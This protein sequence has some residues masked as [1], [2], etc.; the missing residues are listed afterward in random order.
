[1]WCGRSHPHFGGLLG[2]AQ[3]FLFRR[4]KF[5]ERHS[6]TQGNTGRRP[7]RVRLELAGIQIAFAGPLGGPLYR[8]LRVWHELKETLRFRL[9]VQQKHA[10]KH[11]EICANLLRVSVVRR[12]S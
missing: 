5:R 2:P 10:L 4:E 8:V 11:W 6:E 7:D 12:R 3:Y 1:M 9:V